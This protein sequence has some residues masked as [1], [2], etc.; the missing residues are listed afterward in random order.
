MLCSSKRTSSLACSLKILIYGTD[1]SYREYQHELPVLIFSMVLIIIYNGSLRG[2]SS[3]PVIQV[4]YIAESATPH[5]IH[6]SGIPH[7]RLRD[8]HTNNAK[9]TTAIELLTVMTRDTTDALIAIT[10][11]L[12]ASMKLLSDI[13]KALV[14]RRALW[15]T[16]ETRR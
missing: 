3:F 8:N 2:K 14:G 1:V 11:V 6:T 10:V 7:L 15:L 16:I 13:M 5:L 12:I 4:L 9:M